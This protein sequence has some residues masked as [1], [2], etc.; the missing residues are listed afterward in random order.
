MK[1][2]ERGQLT[3]GGNRGSRE[4]KPKLKAISR[5]PTRNHVF[6]TTEPQQDSGTEGSRYLLGVP[7]AEAEE[8]VV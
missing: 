2:G 8:L 1:T 6:C 4:K 5:G 7:G 3:P